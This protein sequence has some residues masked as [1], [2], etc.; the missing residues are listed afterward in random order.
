MLQRFRRRFVI[1]ITQG[2]ADATHGRPPVG[3]IDAVSDIARRHGINGGRVECLGSGRNARLKF[4]SGV[5]E[6]ARQA[7]RNAWT[8]PTPPS[9]GNRRAQG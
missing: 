4:S 8:P 2:R 5:P 6:R 3:F 1:T 9:S 7:I